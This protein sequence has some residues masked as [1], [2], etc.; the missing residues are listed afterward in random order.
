MAFGGENKLPLLFVNSSETESAGSMSVIALF[1]HLS[2][3]PYNMRHRSF[4][5]RANS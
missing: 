4:Y 3:S 2:G 1:Q 5:R